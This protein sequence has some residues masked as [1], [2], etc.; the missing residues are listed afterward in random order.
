MPNPVLLNN[1]YAGQLAGEIVAKALLSN[2]STQYV[3]MKPNVPYKSVV[4]K[5][6]DTV[7]FAAGTC[8]FTPTG[9]INLSERVLTLEEFQVQREIC[10][11]ELFADW[12]TADVMSGRVSTQ[13]Q[14]A[15]IERL[16]GGIAAANET[17]MWNG[18]NG[19]AGQ[20]D[21]FLT[22]IKAGGSGA[23]S[24]GSGALDST[25][26]IATIWDIINTAPAAVKG[27]AEKPALYMGQAAWEAYMQAQI[28]A[29]NGWYLTGGPEVSKR[30]VGMYEIYVCPGM[31]AN[32]IVF[33]QKSNLMLGTWI[34]NQMNEVFIL[35]MQNLDGSQNVR[36]GARFYLG[37]QI[38]VA[39]DITFWGA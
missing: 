38:A 35:D 4:R 11:R 3:T 17:V 24:A 28:A 31:A 25:N 18:V 1:S 13:I 23:V 7:T 29:G 36:Y 27:A 32:N 26:I 12:S 21:G 6:E 10:K 37:A 39:E 14:D 19:T 2:V 30:F 20:Y 22:L 15:I 34:E 5:I 16:V 9:T 33:S 8:D